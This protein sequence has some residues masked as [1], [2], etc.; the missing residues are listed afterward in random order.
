MR[1]FLVRVDGLRKLVGVKFNT[2]VVLCE[3]LLFPYT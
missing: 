1:G 2:L 3:K